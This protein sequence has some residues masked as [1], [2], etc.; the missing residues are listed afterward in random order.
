MLRGGN[1]SILSFVAEFYTQIIKQIFMGKF[2][3]KITLGFNDVGLALLV[4]VSLLF[5]EKINAQTQTVFQENFETG[6]LDSKWGSL[7]APYTATFP[8][9]GAP[10]GTRYLLLSGANTHTGGLTGTIPTS[11]TPNYIS[12]RVK[13]NDLSGS[14][15]SA[16]FVV[17]D[18]NVENNLGYVWMNMTSGTLNFIGSGTTY[19]HPA[20]SNVWYWL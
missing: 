17:G 20:S 6:T 5:S 9:T 1:T 12:Y 19:T 2:Y 3:K 16:Y 13:S 11:Y 15:A 18:S 14:L 7:N 8:T 10:Q 4:L